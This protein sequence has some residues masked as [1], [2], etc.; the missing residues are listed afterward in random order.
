MVTGRTLLVIA[1]LTAA[2]PGWSAEPVRRNGWNCRPRI[3]AAPRRCEPRPGEPSEGRAGRGAGDC[4]GR[5]GGAVF[6]PD[7]RR[8][9]FATKRE[10]GAT[11]Q[12]YILL[13]SSGRRGAA[14]THFGTGRLS[15]SGVPAR[16]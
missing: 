7:S 5:D 8:L 3:R 6:S 16:W 15:Q 2:L 12:I 1:G 4:A 13:R 10:G 11:T 14:T 9:A